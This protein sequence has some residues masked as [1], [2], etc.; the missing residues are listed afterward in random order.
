MLEVMFVSSNPPEDRERVIDESLR[1][2]F[3]ETLDEGI[4]DRFKD[5]LQQLKNQDTTQGRDN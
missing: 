3:E 5:L 1:R 2:V 4:P